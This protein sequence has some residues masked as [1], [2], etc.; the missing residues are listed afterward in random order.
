M[1]ELGLV[2]GVVEGMSLGLSLL[3]ETEGILVGKAVGILERES[4]TGAERTL[5]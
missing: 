3:G 5:Q 4:E 2:L 1:E